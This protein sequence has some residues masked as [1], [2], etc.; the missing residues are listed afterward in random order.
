MQIL[1]FNAAEQLQTVLSTDNPNS[2]PFSEPVHFEK[3]A[4]GSETIENNFT[5]EVPA[6]HSD[7]QYLKEGALVAFLDLDTNWQL[8]EVKDVTDQDTTDGQ[9]N[10]IIYC[11]HALYELIDDIIEDKRPTNTSAFL[12]LTDA[13]SA[14]RWVAGTVN[15]LGTN[16]TRFYYDSA[17]ASIQNVAAVWKG[18]LR[19]RVN[20][21]GNQITGRY[22]DLLAR[23]GADT[24]KQ[25]IFG[26][27]ITS[28]E[29]QVD[30]RNVV[31]ALYGRGKGDQVDTGGYGR[32][33]D[34]STVVWTTPTNPANKPAGQ[35]WIEDTAAK[36]QYGLAGG[37]RNRFDVFVDEEETDPAEL[38][39]KTWDEL[40]RRKVPLTTYTVDAVDLE[41][42]S[43]L[44]H[45]AVRLGDGTVCIDERFSPVLQVSARV[46][47]IARHLTD[48]SKSKFTLGNYR[49]DT[50]TTDA[51][52][53][54]YNRQISDK[55]GVWDNATALKPSVL[56][57]TI[58]ELQ[59]QLRMVNGFVEMIPGEGI[60]V[61]DKPADQSP[62]KAIKLG[63]GILAIANGKVS[64]QWEWR[65]FGTGDGFVADRITTGI[66]L[67]DRIK[68]GTLTLGGLNNTYGIQEFKDSK[69][70]VAGSLKVNPITGDVDAIFGKIE[71]TNAILVQATINLFVDPVNGNDANDGSAY[72]PVKT[73]TKALNLLKKYIQG[74]A[75]IY[76]L[77]GTYNEQVF[78][79]GFH[80]EG[81]LE[82]SLGTST[83]NGCIQAF[84]CTCELYIHG[85]GTTSLTLINSV[86]SSAV[87][88]YGI[89]CTRMTVN[90]VKAKA[91]Q[92]VQYPCRFHWGNYYIRDCSLTDGSFASLL[93][94]MALVF[95]QD[96]KGKSTNYG[97]MAQ[98][99]TCMFVYGMCPTTST[100]S[101]IYNEGGGRVLT[102]SGAPTADDYTGTVP[103][104]R[105]TT[106]WSASLTG[107]F[108]YDY[109]IWRTDNSYIYQG[110]WT[111]GNMCGMWWVSNSSL[112]S[113]LTGK[114]VLSARLYL[115]RMSSGGSS[116][117]QNIHLR[118]FSNADKSSSPGFVG[119]YGYIGAWA[120]GEGKWVDLPTS[121]VTALV[122]GSANALG[123]YDGASG[124]SIFYTNIT[125]EVT[126]QN[127]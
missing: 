119:D 63:G 65:T 48:L 19:F 16:S 125:M 45:E 113:T 120:W 95:L 114:T 68:G 69:D 90:Y 43:G 116:A 46:A 27:D 39:Q 50:G 99:G 107:T 13:L 60:I 103:S 2:C 6:D 83:I 127:S 92:L 40:Q 89:G 49:P 122:N 102:Q 24:G 38:L 35:K 21:A 106:Q 32:R 88:L 8:F 59:N 57:Q 25:F 4:S 97:V 100:G 20:I 52:Q 87:P 55:I 15:D 7:A 31:T 56:D 5:F 14:S 9:L 44:V 11:E 70:D 37:T 121:A 115:E 36:A 72:Y 66:M 81:R 109:N 80:G 26:K 62:T 53:D 98:D 58:F 118:S 3:L 1:V 41:P 94:T 47:A 86:N 61:Y 10:K 79:N 93:A 105:Q 110:A 22:V 78:I 51:K 82:I 96:V 64:G 74:L 117:A 124:Y 104:V 91:N 84:N 28:V 123:L 67:A 71:A 23:R 12:A 73:I 42:L 108:R 33:I 17:L 18:E 30:F 34:F 101:N 112:R 75:V 111:N 77:N 54:Y 29:R 126:Y 76:C 85:G